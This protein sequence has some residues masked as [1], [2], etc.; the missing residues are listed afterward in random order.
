MS[1]SGV[2]IRDVFML[3]PTKTETYESAVCFYLHNFPDFYNLN[4]SFRYRYTGI[5]FIE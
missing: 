3:L 2:I 4:E 1:H 5:N